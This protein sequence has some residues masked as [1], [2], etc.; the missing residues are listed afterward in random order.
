MK[1]TRRQFN[2]IAMAALGVAVLP[3]FAVDLILALNDRAKGQNVYQTADEAVAAIIR[4]SVELII[5]DEADR[6]TVESFDI[7]RHIHDK[8]GCR[9]VV[10]G[11]PEDV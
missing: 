6:L 2:H 8:S 1:L 4:N 7:L 5:V 11:L 10:V 3:A 9:I